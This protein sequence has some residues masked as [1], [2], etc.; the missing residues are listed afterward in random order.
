MVLPAKA[1]GRDISFG[2]A[3]AATRKNSWRLFGGYMLSLLP[4]AAIAGGVGYWLSVA[5]ASRGTA[6][7]VWTIV[8]LLWALFGMVG[9]GFLSLAYRH[10]FERPA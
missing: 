7:A 3:W 9:V 6:T 1:I 10:F 4:F 5:Q 8:T 2:T